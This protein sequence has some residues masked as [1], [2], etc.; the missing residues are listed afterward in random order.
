[1]YYLYILQSIDRKH[2]Y[3]GSSSDLVQR[4]KKHNNGSSKSTKPYRPWEIIYKKE[5]TTK[6]EA[7]KKEYF[8]KSPKG[9]LEKIKIFNEHKKK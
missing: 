1:M 2:F 5:F 3:I 4:L 9:Y 7:V 8:L 6:E